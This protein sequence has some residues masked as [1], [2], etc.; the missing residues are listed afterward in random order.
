MKMDIG[1]SVTGNYSRHQT[2]IFWE[3]NIPEKREGDAKP[4]NYR[5]YLL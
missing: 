4:R 1:Y 2:G 5:L 3:K